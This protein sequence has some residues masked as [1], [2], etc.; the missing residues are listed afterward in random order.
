[1]L[2]VALRPPGD[3]DEACGSAR[4]LA[5]LVV[6]F[7]LGYACLA[8]FGI[9]AFPCSGDEYSYE[10]QAEIFARGRLSVATPPHPELFDV[11]HVLLEP[12]VRS[13]YPPGWPALLALGSAAGAPWI[14]NPI[15]GALSLA[16]VYAIARKAYGTGPALAATLLLGCSPIFA[17]HAAS[18]LSHTSSLAALLAFVACIVAGW[19]KRSTAWA[20]LGGA[21]LGFA[22]L[23][24]QVEAVLYGFALMPLVP[25]APRYVAAC[26]AGAAVVASLLL[27]YHAAQF[28]SPWTTGYALYDPTQ[29]RLYGESNGSPVLLSNLLDVAA[30]WSHAQWLGAL[31]AHLAPGV[32]VLAA[33]GLARREPL[34]PRAVLRT[35]MLVVTS[36]QLVLMLFYGPDMG[37]V[38]GPRYLFSLLGPIAFGVAAAWGPLWRW[39]T[40]RSET[41]ASVERGLAAAV[42][43]VLAGGL[44]RGAFLLDQQ[45]AELLQWTRLYDRVR[46]RH[47]DN[48]VVIV[49]GPFPTRW[50]RNGI[51]FDGPVLYVNPALDGAAVARLYP[52]RS[53]YVAKRAH[54]WAD[55]VI[56][57]E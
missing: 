47:L 6:V 44:V 7:A 13:K 16:L 33:I 53:I 28:G 4:G 20:L 57:R 24:R 9:D 30:Q 29:R 49:N 25:R 39:V 51:T 12:S 41:R 38:F 48:A 55:W 32:G 19:E 43:L 52:T 8:R 45:R 14:V 23:N 21:A 50:T 22:F 17:F 31:A 15:L 42:A 10:L 34:E 1:M 11:D 18:Y 26:A 2:A 37:P 46:E 35:M 27:V 36:T 5:V 3:R 54:E 56:D 40:T